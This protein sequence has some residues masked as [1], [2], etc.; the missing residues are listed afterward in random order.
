MQEQCVARCKRASA[1]PSPA[2][3]QPEGGICRERCEL[4][5]QTVMRACMALPVNPTREQ[6]Q[7]RAAEAVRL[8][9]N[10]VC[11]RKVPPAPDPQ[12][13]KDKCA[14]KA[15]EAYAACVKGSTGATPEACERKAR[16]ALQECLKNCPGASVSPKPQPGTGECRATC[17]KRVDA[18]IEQCASQPGSSVERCEA[19]GAKKLEACLANCP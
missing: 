4:V 14:M 16:Q 10:K 3:R 13:C 2:P 18:F 15:R 8:C 1:E 17:R 11:P 12:V 9:I 5:G 7:K 6:C 19:A